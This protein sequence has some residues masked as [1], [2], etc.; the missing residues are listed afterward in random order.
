[1][2]IS[3]STL[4]SEG[5]SAMQQMQ[6]N[7]ARTNLQIATG[8]RMLS[9]ADDPA[10]AARAIELKQSDASNTQLASNRATATNTLS[11]AE[12][13]LSSVTSVLQ[14]LK[15]LGVETGGVM[16][17][18]T[19]MKGIAT[20]L[21]GRMQEL[22]GLANSTDGIGNY[23]FSGGQGKVQPFVNTSAGTIYQGDDVQRRI[24][25]S[26]SRQM[27]ATEVGS[28][29]FMRVRNGNGSFQTSAA[30]GNTGTATID[31]GRVL[32]A[33]FNGNSYRVTFTSAT[34][35]DVQNLTSGTPVSTGNAYVSGQAVT[36]EG[37]Q[38]EIGGNPAAG[39]TFDVQASAN[40]SVFATLEAFI[41]LADAPPAAGDALS[42]AKF[43]QGLQTVIGTL[44]QV[45]NNVLSTRATIG[46]R[47][48]EIDSLQATGESLGL[49]YKNN[50]SK[51]QDTDYIQAVTD[52][53]KQQLALQASQQSFARISQLS[54]FDF[55]R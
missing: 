22:L 32:A 15:S 26:A 40:Q 11:L 18:A 5:V 37:I 41:A 24:Q 10:A 13:V 2:R 35:F 1:M 19:S 49:Q 27:A 29:I 9:P 45:L 8:Q 34:T 43:Q 28:D 25:V 30:A 31:Q 7:L 48:R 23:L 39:D 42:A 46:G 53:N 21:R 47:L 20:T 44:D 33:P 51:I 16:T 54:L 14:E 55:L 17:N 50:L 6:N 38:F 36:F 4:F 3:T 12:G 52:L